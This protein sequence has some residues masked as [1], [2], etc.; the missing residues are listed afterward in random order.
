MAMPST[1]WSLAVERGPDWLFVRPSELEPANSEGIE[2]AEAIW[3]EM[4]RHF[5]NRVVV[6]CTSVPVMHSWLIGQLVL[7][8]KRVVTHGGMVRLCGLSANNAAVLHAA[9]LDD[10][11]P[12]YGTREAAVMGHRPEQPR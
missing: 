8:H 9:R 3:Q 1:G 7:L 5:T 12:A 2:L 4:Q 6:D 11:F 10:R